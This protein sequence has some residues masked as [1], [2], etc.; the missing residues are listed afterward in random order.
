MSSSRVKPGVTGRRSLS[1]RC[2]DSGLSSLLSAHFDVDDDDDDDSILD[3]HLSRVWRNPDDSWTAEAG[4]G[5]GP[6]RWR[7][8]GSDWGLQS[9]ELISADEDAA[10]ALCDAVR[11]LEQSSADGG[12]TCWNDMTACSYCQSASVRRQSETSRVTDNVDNEHVVT[13]NCCCCC[14]SCSHQRCQCRRLLSF[15]NRQT[16]SVLYISSFWF[17]LPLA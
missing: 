15:Y 12:D 6:T 1:S 11:R 4:G 7:R 3:E 10:A 17:L 8:T 14:C 5:P 16:R 9:G 13:A 2:S